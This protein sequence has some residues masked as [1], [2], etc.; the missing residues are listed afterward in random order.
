[1]GTIR[2]ENEILRQQNAALSE[3]VRSGGQASGQQQGYPTPPPNFGSTPS[4]QLGGGGAPRPVNISEIGGIRRIS[5]T[6][7]PALT[8]GAGQQTIRI[9]YFPTTT[10]LKGTLLN[11][12]YAPTLARGRSMPH[13][14]FIRIDDISILP[15]NLPKDIEGC[16]FMGEAYG[17]LM[18]SRVHIR[19]TK[20]ACTAY[21][22]S[23]YFDD[24]VR[25]VVIGEDGT[26]GVPGEIRA[27]FNKILGASFFMESMAGLGRAIQSLST[28]TVIGADGTAQQY[29]EGSGADQAGRILMAAG[30]QGLGAGFERIAGFY[31]DMLNEMSPVIQ[32]HGGRN[33]EIKLTEGVELKLQPNNW[34]W[35]DVL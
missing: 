17:E 24:N 5:A 35:G 3:R 22:G 31:L 12:L 13:P 26:L 30:G 6:I 20:M 4:G 2:A 29:I 23:K 9:N 25:G 33:L 27:N 15:N 11:G 21:D 16:E 1:M 14:A 32:I 8:D 10:Y 18:D 34:S 19:L 7:P 28:T